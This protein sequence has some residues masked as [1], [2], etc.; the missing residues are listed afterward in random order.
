MFIDNE[1]SEKVHKLGLPTVGQFRDAINLQII[2][3]GILSGKWIYNFKDLEAFDT[4]FPVWICSRF[5]G[6]NYASTLALIIHNKKI[7]GLTKIED[8]FCLYAAWHDIDSLNQKILQ[9][10][11]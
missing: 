8:W 6:K 2:E 7:P 4:E 3:K 9:D 1:L 10:S 5:T 11:Q